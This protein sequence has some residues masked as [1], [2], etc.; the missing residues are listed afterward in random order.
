M[1]KSILALTLA[2]AGV[3]V[4]ASTGTIIVPKNIE[5]SQITGTWSSVNR[6]DLVY[7]LNPSK[8]QFEV[9]IVVNTSTKLVPVD[10]IIVKCNGTNFAVPAGSGISCI[11][12]QDVSWSDGGGQNG[13]SG[14]Y[15]FHV[16]TK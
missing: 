4:F 14:T 6:N 13:S 5:Q 8:A 10:G 16:L 15:E 1:K 7:V 11:T 3:G 9:N 2:L 12:Q